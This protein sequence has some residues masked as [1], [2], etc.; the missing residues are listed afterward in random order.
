MAE[1]KGELNY[2]SELDLNRDPFAPEPDLTFFYE[3][4]SLENS[5]AV[6][7]RLVQGDEIIVLVIGQAGSGKTS[8]LKRYLSASIAGWKTGRIRIQPEAR[9]EPGQ[10][11]L[12]NENEVDSYP[13]YFLQDIKDSIIIIDDTHELSPR[14][15]TFLIRNTQLSSSTGT[16]KRFILFGEPQLMDTVNALT[17]SLSNET[18]VS[19]I[20]LPS[21][22]REQT[23][24]YMNYR[25]AVAGYAGKR[26]FRSSSAKKIHR[27]SGGLP[28][29]IN[30]MADQQLKKDFSK[31]KQLQ[32]GFFGWIQEHEKTLN[33][34]AAGLAVLIISL[35]VVFYYRGVQPSQPKSLALANRVIR[36]KI[37]L[38]ARFEKT[39]PPVAATL[40]SEKQNPDISA[41]EKQTGHEPENISAVEKTIE[42]ASTS[43]EAIAP[44]TSATPE[45]TAQPEANSEK[46]NT[47]EQAVYREK[48]LLSQNSSFYTIQIL[49]VH[50]EGRL[51]RFIESDLPSPRTNLAYYQTS[52]RGKDWYPLLY[53]VYASQKDASSALKKLPTHIQKSSPWIRRLS[54]VQKTI[55]KQS[56]P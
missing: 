49:G 11:A 15:L 25:L 19:K 41:S 27:L 13:A 28:G 26:L 56:R 8:L 53:G 29:R 7:N 4:E 17:T 1:K 44:K 23:M 12:F 50:D 21:M 55:Q 14:H 18:A 54:S 36:G 42:M 10:P 39:L 46:E 3:Y 16:V 52:Y 43:Q 30:T 51:L 2:I 47:E 38:P 37:E 5:Y 45:G 6:L 9:T 34:S 32:K 22:T 24:G 40:S 33:W 35:F 48:W 31:E 20:F